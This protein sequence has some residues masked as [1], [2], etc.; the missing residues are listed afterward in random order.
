MP[1]NR[2]AVHLVMKHCSSSYVSEPHHMC[3]NFASRPGGETV[4][5][6]FTAKQ[7]DA[8]GTMESFSGDY[9]VPSY[10]GSSFMDPKVCFVT[11]WIWA[12]ELILGSASIFEIGGLF[13][14]VQLPRFMKI[15]FGIKEG[16]F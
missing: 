13:M 6:L 15:R 1:S 3:L 10:R 4:P 14:R 16:A 2:A 9:L 8:K 5:F 12:A 11:L 7:L